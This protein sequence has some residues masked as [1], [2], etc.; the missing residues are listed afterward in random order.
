MS[1]FLFI[2]PLKAESNASNWG[3]TCQF[4]DRSLKAI[5]GQDCSDHHT[6]IVCNES[7]EITANLERTTV[8]PTDIRVDGSFGQFSGRKDKQKKCYRGL[9]EAREMN[10][11]YVMI[12]DSDDL[13][14]R[15]LVSY[16]LDR[17][18][19]GGFVV[20]KGYR[21][22]LGRPFLTKSVA[23]HQIS[24]SSAICPYDPEDY[25][26]GATEDDYASS[27]ITKKVHIKT[28]E[29]DF[30]E[31]GVP[32]R[33]IPFFA[34]IYTRGH[35]DSLRDVGQKARR[36]EGDPVKRKRRKIDVLRKLAGRLLGRQPINYSVI[37]EFPGLADNCR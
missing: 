26:E 30:R 1:K 7:P 3:K 5:E 16:C 8:I 31:M 12:L 35:G 33:R 4:L 18:E 34:A 19:Y 36:A 23:F 27:Y 24:A 25:P 32:F 6:F 15:K 20:T 13:V 21:Q 11:D 9:I 10:P 28:I 22:D 14:H 37:R 29:R 2:I 17:P